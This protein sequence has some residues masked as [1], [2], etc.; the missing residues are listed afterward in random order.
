M[1]SIEDALKYLKMGFSVIPVKPRD[2]G[3]AVSWAE[4][5][6]RQPT[7]QEIKQW[8]NDGQFNIA[9][10]CGKVS[11]NLIVFDFDNLA[12]VPFVI[13]DVSEIAKKTMV[14]RT[15]KGYHVYYKAKRLQTS[16]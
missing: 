11:G 7:E 6:K 8:F 4:Y 16:S 1:A 10:I 15:G 14:V 5:Q 2:K 3:A 13:G 9:I 12:T